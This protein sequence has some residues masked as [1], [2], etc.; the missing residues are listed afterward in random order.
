MLTFRFSDAPQHLRRGLFVFLSLLVVPLP[1]NVMNV[2]IG[3]VLPPQ[4]C[5]QECIGSF[6]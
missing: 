1:V 3:T 4:T 2:T 5:K 6:H